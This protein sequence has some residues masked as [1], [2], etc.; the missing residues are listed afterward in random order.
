MKMKDI[1][2]S[3]AEHLLQIKAIK[4]EPAKPFVW[5]SGWL[6]PIYC[7]NRLILSYPET[8]SL[9]CQSFSYMITSV[10]PSATVIAGV[11]TGAIAHG[12]LV[13]DRLDLPFVYVRPSPKSHGMANL[14]EGRVPAGARVVIIEDLISTGRSSLA[15]VE[16][17]KAV[18]CEILGM[19]AIFTY[20][21]EIALENFMANSCELH[22]LTN[23]HTLIRV[24]RDM[25]FV[26]DE[27]L[28]TLRKWRENPAA[29]GTEPA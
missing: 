10:Y 3:I 1:D 26:G 27:Q 25:G 23:Y 22:T 7:D 9:I 17:L 11:A 4:L 12:V 15:A 28:D 29:W 18:E 16:A 13:A 2:K 19:V 8:R 5:A 14:I 6:S 24:A 21:F 20:G